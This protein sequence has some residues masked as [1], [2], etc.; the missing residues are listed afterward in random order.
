MG[1]HT[2]VIGASEN[3]ERYSNKAIRKL[4]QY[5]HPVT[6]IGNREGKVEGI[7]F[8]KTRPNLTDI[9]TVTMYI[10]PAHQEEYVD[11]IFS[12]HPKRIIFNPGTENDEFEA[13]AAQQG[14]QVMEACTLV[15]LSTGQY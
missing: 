6:A 9:D 2:L 15:L 4:V 10:G 8:S 12:L 11:Y 1:K 13:K 14:I 7:S 5:N 3:T